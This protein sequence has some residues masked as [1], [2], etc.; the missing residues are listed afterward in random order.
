M[1]KIYNLP[2]VLALMTLLAGCH[3]DTIPL[4]S[5]PMGNVYFNFSGGDSVTYTF[6]YNPGLPSDTVWLPIQ[7]SG[8]QSKGILYYKAMVLDSGTTAVKGL[9]Y[10]P[11]LDSFQI[12]ANTGIDSMPVIVYS[13]DTLLKQQSVALNIRL[14]PSGSLGTQIADMINAKVIISDKLEK[15]SWWDLWGLTNYSDEKYELY[16]IATGGRN[17]LPTGSDYGL[18]APEALY[19]IG[20]MNNLISDP[21]TWIAQNPSRDYVLVKQPDG[22]YRFYNTATPDS[23]MPVVYNASVSRYYF[24]QKSGGYVTPN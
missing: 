12:P 22:T 13:Q 20:Q 14:V 16:I 19:F 18:Y 8:N 21:V 23:Y 9:D 7:I 11:L 5:Q 15:P 3:K 24:V 6:S 10:Q 17:D 1:N 4:Y 2:A